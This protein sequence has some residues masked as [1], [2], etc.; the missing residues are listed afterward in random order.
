[1]Q[2]VGEALIYTQRSMGVANFSPGRA[3]VDLARRWPNAFSR[4]GP[5]VMKLHFTNSKLRDKHFST[6]KLMGKYQMSKPSGGLVVTLFH[7][8]MFC[9]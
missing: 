5:T 7:L 4:S 3:I 1:V 6:K 8:L 9:S 2:I